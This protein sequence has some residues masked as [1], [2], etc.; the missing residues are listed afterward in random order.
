[1]GDVRGLMMRWDLVGLAEVLLLC[2]GWSLVVSG[3]VEGMIGLGLLG[4]RP[5][6]EFTVLLMGEEI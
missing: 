5:C 2:G 3:N 6:V 1:M 4:V